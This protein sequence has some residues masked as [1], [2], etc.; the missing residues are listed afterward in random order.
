MFSLLYGFWEYLFKK[1]DYFILI[2]GLDNSGKTTLLEH[3]RIK[4]NK[5]FRSIDLNRIASTVGL[6]VGRIEILGIRLNFWDLGGQKELRLLWDKYFLEAHGIIWVVDASDRERLQESKQSFDKII[7]NQLLDGLPL[8]FVIN[9][10]D[11]PQSMAPDEII[12]T[13]KS[14]LNL[15]GDRRF[16]TIST[17]A[18]KGDGVKQSIEWIAARVKEGAKSPAE[19]ILMR[20]KQSGNTITS[21]RSSKT[22]RYQ[23]IASIFHRSRKLRQSMNSKS[24]IVP[25]MFKQR[26]L[27]HLRNFLVVLLVILFIT[28]PDQKSHV[29]ADD[30]T[31]QQET[32]TIK[33]DQPFPNI[34]SMSYMRDPSTKIRIQWE[35]IR[36]DK[37]RS[38]IEEYTDFHTVSGSFSIMNSDSKMSYYSDGQARTFYQYQPYRCWTVTLD[39]L[40][41]QRLYGSWLIKHKDWYLFGVSAVWL[42][43]T[44][45][46]K[47]YS[48]SKLIES[49]MNPGDMI[50]DKWTVEDRSINRYIHIY[51]S[52]QN[53]LVQVIQFEDMISREITETINVFSIDFQLTDLEKQEKFNLPLGYGC[54]NQVEHRPSFEYEPKSS[55]IQFIGGHSDYYLDIDVSLTDINEQTGAHTSANL[56]VQIARVSKFSSNFDERELSSN[57]I[58][59]VIEQRSSDQK[60]NYKSVYDQDMGTMF[61]ISTSS[62]SNNPKCMLMQRTEKGTNAPKQ[63]IDFGNNYKFELSP[64][65]EDLLFGDNQHYA[66]MQR[67]WHPNSDI[68]ELIYENPTA[69]F[70]SPASVL[71]VYTRE[72]KNN[73]DISLTRVVVRIY[74]RQ[75]TILMLMLT[76]NVIELIKFDHDLERALLFDVSACFDRPE[77][78]AWLEFRYTS[79]EPEVV[80]ILEKNLDAV[81]RA[82][83]ESQLQLTPFRMPKCEVHIDWFGDLVVRALVL[84]AVPL[85]IAYASKNEMSFV[86]V[87]GAQHVLASDAEHCASY[88]EAHKCK[89]FSFCST[90]HACDM[91]DNVNISAPQQHTNCRVYYQDKQTTEMDAHRVPL[92]YIVGSLEA[93]NYDWEHSSS[94]DNDSGYDDDNESDADDDDYANKA[95]KKLSGAPKATLIID[96]KHVL[97]P[98]ELKVERRSSM[99]D[100]YVDELDDRVDTSFH[101]DFQQMRYLI[102]DQSATI[103]HFQTYDQCAI[104]CIDSDCG[105]FSYCWSEQECILTNHSS[106][107]DIKASTMSDSNCLVAQRDYLN[108]YTRYDNVGRPLSSTKQTIAISA[109]DCAHQCTTDTHIRCRAFDYCLGSTPHYELNAPKNGQCFM[110]IDRKATIHAIESKQMAAQK[111]KVASKQTGC[112]HYSRNLLAE[113]DKYPNKE[114]RAGISI[115]LTSEGIS[116]DKCAEQCAENDHCQVF[117]FCYEDNH[118]PH[119]KCRLVDGRFS[120]DD[121]QHSNSCTV[122]SMHQGSKSDN[123]RNDGNQDEDRYG[124]RLI[125]TV[126]IWLL[127]SATI[128]VFVGFVSSWIK[129]YPD[130]FKKHSDRIKVHLGLVNR[131]K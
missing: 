64:E 53:Q 115:E 83:Y 32:E 21:K 13:F 100:G 96:N 87:I 98:R 101:Q 33:W 110:H 123:N 79:I 69:Y 51:I 81:K 57:P 99:L 82:F 92:A 118:E 38:F 102:T 117:Q 85:T 77:Q 122:Y 95:R 27:T 31:I 40:E 29:N 55:W 58:Y 39:G 43:A 97:V 131:I 88:C 80:A 54:G 23:R 5:D 52:S 16:C 2:L 68:E 44:Y 36:K 76:F 130:D 14:S 103:L 4:Y 37:K 111:R 18:L 74:N 7:R 75:R 47:T 67:K 24:K 45:L 3:A 106:S 112:D 63:E 84:D 41:Q 113:F 78:H 50:A 25:K 19:S 107:G 22:N 104:A 70:N 66:F 9:K 26:N 73:D 86:N 62:G 90:N 35:L 128:A 116:L 65:M 120:N 127:V 11:L 34:E 105:S 61:R 46:P 59:T 48:P 8:A 94:A 129:H 10:R 28:L 114:V 30:S 12:E 119:L 17:S 49:A 6:N 124:L 1:G 89:S 56:A 15:I 121:M 71:R 93:D 126:M 91:L 108:L 42:A 20:P 109:S 125:P 60:L 72:S